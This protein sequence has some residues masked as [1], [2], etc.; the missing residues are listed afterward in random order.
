MHLSDIFI[1]TA[2][3]VGV[4]S[5][6]VYF[7]MLVAMYAFLANLIF[8]LTTHSSIVPE[9]RI[10]RV[11]GAIIA[12]VAG[13]SYYFIQDY[14]RHMLA[15]LS[16]LGTEA[17]RQELI[18]TSYNAIGQYRYMDW[19]VTTPL[20]LLKMV[21]MLRVEPSKAKGAIT[22]LLLADFFMVLTGYIGEQQLDA[23]GHILVGPKLFWG[24]V[25]TVGYLVVPFVL[26]R[27]WNRFKDQAKPIERKSFKIIALS[28]VTTWGVYPLGYVLSVLDI[29]MN[30]IHLSFSVAD[31]INKVGL[32]VV[33]Y[34]AGKTLLDER[35]PMEATQPAYQIN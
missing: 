17:E 10:T 28:T 1:P 32:S 18:R 7:F 11:M 21:S 14:Y 3:N 19:A 35:V 27:L 30:W 6:V 22:A 12:A 24:A 16:A 33:V 9:H 4:L 2:A 25:S 29:D 8:T 23:A 13:L 31:I 5:M 34:L 26:Y 20:L 15:D